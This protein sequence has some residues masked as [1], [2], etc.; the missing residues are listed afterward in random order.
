MIAYQAP[1]LSYYW[2]GDNLLR[3]YIAQIPQSLNTDARLGPVCVRIVETWL[4]ELIGEDNVMMLNQVF[5][6]QPLGGAQFEDYAEDIQKWVKPLMPFMAHAIW[7]EYIL[8]ANVTITTTGPVTVYG[9]GSEP[10]SDQQRKEISRL[11]KGY[12]DTYALKL[13][14]LV[15]SFQC[16]GRVGSGRPSLKAAGGRRRSRFDS[17]NDYPRRKTVA[18]PSTPTPIASAVINLT[19]QVADNT[20]ALSNKMATIVA[21]NYQDAVSKTTALPADVGAMVTILADDSEGNAGTGPNGGNPTTF[22]LFN[23]STGLVQ[24]VMYP[25]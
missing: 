17:G 13:S 3:N 25:V 21:N 24:Q 12:A 14:K 22:Y 10:L 9:D 15:A 4:T 16:G 8:I 5:S 6:E 23:H 7:S 18:I 11:H 2:L 1:I 19:N 20:A